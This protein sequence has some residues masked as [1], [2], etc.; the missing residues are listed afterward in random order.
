MPFELTNAPPYFQKVMNDVFGDMN[1]VMVYMDDI[2][3]I[4]KNPKL[5]Q[6]HLDAVFKRL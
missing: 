2:T 4:S 6:Q 1:F 3:I 5:H